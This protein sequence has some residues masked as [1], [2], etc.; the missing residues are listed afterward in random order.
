M[1]C[2]PDSGSQNGSGVKIVVTN[3]ISKPKPWI[4]SSLKRK[5]VKKFVGRETNYMTSYPK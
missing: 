5:S 3:L 1:K 2:K 4:F